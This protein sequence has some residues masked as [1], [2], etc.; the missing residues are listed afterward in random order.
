M[1][2]KKEKKEGVVKNPNAPKMTLKQKKKAA[3]AAEVAKKS[4]AT[5]PTTVA[6]KEQKSK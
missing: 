4:G 1:G 5:K 3:A 2:G 6:V